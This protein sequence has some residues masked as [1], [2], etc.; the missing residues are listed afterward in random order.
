MSR[1]LLPLVPLY[2]AAVSAKNLAYNRGWARAQQLRWPVIS[3][4]NLSVG[5]SG[6]T[7]LVIRLVELLREQEIAVDVLSRGYGRKS[8]AVARVDPDGSADDFGDEPLLIARATGIP[9]FVGGSRY[10]AGEL[11]E[12]SASASR[13]HLLD[14]GFQHRQLARA[15]DIVVLHRSDFSVRLLPAGRLREGFSALRRAQIVAMREEDQDLEP[16][17]RRRGCQLPI[18]WMSR[19]LETPN[20]SS[21]IAFC[22]IAHPDEFAAELQRQGIAVAATRFWRDH[23]RYGEADISALIALQRQHQAEAFLTTEKDLVR[24]SASQRQTLQAAAPLHTA[25]LVVRLR[26]EGAAIAQILGFLP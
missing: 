6:K 12:R 15:V 10:A 17:V 26:D 11:A 14:D 19:R 16:E 7:P 2:A 4:G 3:V 9:V 24:L 21:A 13:V 5:G 22:A 1:V 18:W 25:K 20:L 23:H 8:T